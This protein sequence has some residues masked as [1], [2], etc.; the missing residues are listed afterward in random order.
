MRSLL[1]LACVSLACVGDSPEIEVASAGGEGSCEPGF[2][3]CECLDGSCN[4][5]LVC[6]EGICLV[7]TGEDGSNDGKPPG[8]EGGGE[9]GVCLASCVRRADCAG[10][11]PLFDEKNWECFE[12]GCVWLGCRHDGECGEGE[13]CLLAEE[14]PI[15]VSACQQSD[16]CGSGEG[17]FVPENY[18]CS[19]GACEYLGCG[20]D[21]EC[22][23]LEPS[24]LCFEEHGSA[25]LQPCE[26]TGDCGSA[27]LTCADGACVPSGCIVDGDCEAGYVCR[28]RARARRR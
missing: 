22:A 7:N 20:A 27:E 16:D 1:L 28:A 3:A 19:D 17:P 10:E 11:P 24:S 13:R 14:V 5:G 12:G 18:A 6:S 4:P 26:V 25:C 2:P 21:E 15:C 23:Q 8:A 9:P